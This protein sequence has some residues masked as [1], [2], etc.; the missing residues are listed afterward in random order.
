[1]SIFTVAELEYLGGQPLGRLAT[2]GPDGAPQTRPVGFSYNPQL[3]TIDIGGHDLAA[4]QKYRNVRRD[5]RVSFVVDDLASTDPWSPR[6]VEIR[7]RA[8][9]IDATD[10]LREGFTA[11]R[12]RI[13]PERVLGWGLD[14][15]AFA[16]PHARTASREPSDGDG[17][18]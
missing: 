17:S 14:T 12:I 1:M 7:G 6:G 2:L 13:H 9:T 15:D 16:A 10:P 18:A 11:D 3:D 5:P 8:E 4:S